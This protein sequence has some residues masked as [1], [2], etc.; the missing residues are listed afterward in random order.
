VPLAFVLIGLAVVLLVGLLAVGWFGDLPESS[1]DRAPL[2]LPPG[3][4][5]PQDVT[6]VRFAVGA[7]GYRMDEVDAV[8]ERVT[9]DLA[10]R[11]AHIEFLQQRFGSAGIDPYA[12]SADEMVQPVPQPEPPDPGTAPDPGPLDPTDP[13][14]TSPGP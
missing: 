12:S 10:E 5:D 2:N 3:R 14:P 8:L 9:T 13:D 4:L 11:D 1:P 6:D 7:R